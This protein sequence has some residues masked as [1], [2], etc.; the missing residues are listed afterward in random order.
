METVKYPCRKCSKEVEDI[1][2]GILCEGLRQS[3]Y[4]ASCVCVT[5]EEYDCLAASD[6]RWECPECVG[7]AL[8]P[9][10]SKDVMDVFHF[11]FQKNLPTPKIAVGQQFY[12][13]LLWTYSA[14]E[15]KSPVLHTYNVF[16]RAVSWNVSIAI[17]SNLEKVILVQYK[18]F[19]WVHFHGNEFDL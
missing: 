14:T 6:D 10:N 17:P 4:H 16:Q 12:L 7:D 13:R 5:D 18:K 8:P 9:H 15:Q 2:N 19:G 11:D 1:E 3:W